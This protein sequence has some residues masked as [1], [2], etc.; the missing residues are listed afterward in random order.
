MKMKYKLALASLV[1]ALMTLVPSAA[2]ASTPGV[3]HSHSHQSHDRTP[4]VHQ[5]GATSHHS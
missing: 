5:H 1:M 4:H 2:H 3:T